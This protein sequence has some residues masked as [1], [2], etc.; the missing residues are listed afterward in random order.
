MKRP[1]GSKAAVI[2]II[3]VAVIIFIGLYYAWST[4]T[5]IF[6]PV[7]DAKNAKTVSITVKPGETTADIAEKLEKNGIIKNAFAFRLWSR[8]RGLDGKLQAGVYNKLNSSMT[9]DKIIDEFMNAQPDATQVLVKEGY[10]LEEIANAVAQSSPVLVNFK[11]DEFLKYAH[12]IKSFPD[13]GKYP[14]LKQISQQSDSMEGF[15]FPATYEIPVDADARVVIQRMITKTTEVLQENKLEALAKQHQMSLYDLVTLAS[16]VERETGKVEEDR[17]NIASVYWNRLYKVNPEIGKLL[18]A[19]PTVQYARDNQEKPAKYWTPLQD[20]GGNVY[21]DSPY[22][23][24][25]Q[26]GLPPTPI[27]SPGLASLKA[28]AERPDTDYYYFFA[29]KTGKSHFAKTH[30]EF[31][32]LMAQYGVSGA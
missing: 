9:I 1:G 7:S 22:N 31:T 6:L 12:N 15:L 14:L 26:A 24:Y 25:T 13:Y 11:K 28:V 30:A 19:D 4:V 16:V 18:Q 8:V 21:P 20:S 17:P 2:S 5:S 23:T 3:L 29:D 27:C 32:Q 10:R